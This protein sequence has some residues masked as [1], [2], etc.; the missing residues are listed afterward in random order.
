MSEKGK[1]YKP[2]YN[3]IMGSFSRVGVWVALV[4]NKYYLVAHYTVPFID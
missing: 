3:A 1:K 4:G 2:H